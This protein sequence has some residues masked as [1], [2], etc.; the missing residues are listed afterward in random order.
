MNT[1]ANKWVYLE[2][3]FTEAMALSSVLF[4]LYNTNNIKYSFVR[5]TMHTEL[6][7]QHPAINE[8]GFPSKDEPMH[9]FIFE[10]ANLPFQKICQQIHG[11]LDGTKQG[12]VFSP[13]LPL[14]S[15]TFTEL[16]IFKKSGIKVLLLTH[17]SA[18]N[19]FVDPMMLHILTEK[20]I[21][22]NCQVIQYGNPFFPHIKGAG[23]IP[24]INSLM[25][26]QEL[27][28][29]V[30]LVVSTELFSIPLSDFYNSSL[31]LLTKN[32]SSSIKSKVGIFNVEDNVEK[33]INMALSFI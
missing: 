15:T 17:L 8:I 22:N 4:D 32:E 18:E 9:S 30:D 20:L 7:S 13:W 12:K 27:I 2:G 26:I 28:K 24:G 23:Y 33:L 16:D 3:G 19:N 29:S 25:E 31:I 5:K 1:T 10:G 14:V 6:F 21:R 11:V